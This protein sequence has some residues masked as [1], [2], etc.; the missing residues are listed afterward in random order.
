MRCVNDL[1]NAFVLSYVAE[2]V[3][4]SVDS[5]GG[6]VRWVWWCVVF[7]GFCLKW[8]CGIAYLWMVWLIP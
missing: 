4:V 7:G 5:W 2:V 3:L 6:V 1:V 8:Y